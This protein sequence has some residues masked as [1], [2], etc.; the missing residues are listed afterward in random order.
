MLLVKIMSCAPKIGVEF[1]KNTKINPVVNRLIQN[2]GTLENFII[3]YT[4]I[5]YKNI[6]QIANI[7]VDKKCKNRYIHH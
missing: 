5:G 3:H 1:F 7:R 2:K 4:S 6:I